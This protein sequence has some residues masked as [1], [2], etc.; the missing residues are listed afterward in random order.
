MKFNK[1]GFLIHFVLIISMLGLVTAGCEEEDTRSSPQT[2]QPAATETSTPP[3]TEEPTPTTPAPTSTD[4]PPEIP[5]LDSL[6]ID[7]GAF[8]S[9][10]E[11]SALPDAS[12]YGFQLASYERPNEEKSSHGTA[13][14]GDQS[15]WNHAAFNVGIWS[16]IIVVGLAVPVA[17]FAASFHNIPLQQPDGS[18]VWSYD[19]RVGGVVHSAELH[20]KYIA[21]GVRWDMYISKDGHYS[22]FHW[23]YGESDLPATEGF[24]V[25]KNK[26]SDPTDLLRIDW[27]RSIEDGTGDIKYTNI[28][29]GGPENGGY[30]YMENTDDTPYGSYWDI[31]NKGKDN[32]TYIEW[33]RN[34]QT[35]R[36]KDAKRFGDSQWHCWDSNHK[37]TECP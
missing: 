15:Y 10:G 18:W 29:P 32:H 20:G 3:V 31:Y 25:L 37:N 23:F 2:T 27:H 21:D 35:G 28:V 11:T 22:D 7:F 16:A 4:V 12:Q 6:K 26:P 34:T 24:W 13:A 30:I 8:Q 17:A 33:N 1:Y 19:V 14:L 5:P 36:V 9:L